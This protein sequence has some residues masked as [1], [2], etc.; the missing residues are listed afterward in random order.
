L[1]QSLR[2][3]GD[4]SGLKRK[5]F[6]YEG[7]RP[8]V[9]ERR[10]L[11]DERERL[12]RY[13]STPTSSVANCGSDCATAGETQFLLHAFAGVPGA[14]EFAEEDDLAGVVGVVGADVGDRGG[15]LLEVGVVGGLDE[16]LEVG[17]DLVELL[18]G[19]GPGGCVELVE[20]LLV[21]AVV[22]GGLGIPHVE[23]H[24]PVPEEEVVGEHADGM[25]GRCGIFVG[26]GWGDPVGLLGGEAADGGVDGDEPLGLVVGGAELLDEDRAEV[27]GFGPGLR[28]GL[29][30]GEGEGGEEEGEE[31]SIEEHARSVLRP[32]GM[33]FAGPVEGYQ[34][35][36]WVGGGMGRNAGR[37]VLGGGGGGWER[38]ACFGAEAHRITPPAEAVGD[39][40]LDAMRRSPNGGRGAA[41][42]GRGG[43]GGGGVDDGA[44]ERDLVGGKA[45]HLGVFVD[46]GLVGR[47]V[48]AVDLVAGDEA[49]D[50]LELGADGGD[51]AAGFLG[52]GLELVRG[53]VAG[54]GDLAL[55]DEFGHG[56]LARGGWVEGLRGRVCAGGGGVKRSVGGP[57]DCVSGQVDGG[58]GNVPR[59][60]LPNDGN[61]ATLVEVSRVVL[62]CRMVLCYEMCFSLW[63]DLRFGAGDA[64]GCGGSEACSEYFSLASQCFLYSALRHQRPAVV[65]RVQGDSE[66]WIGY[67]SDRLEELGCVRFHRL[68][69]KEQLRI[70]WLQ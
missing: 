8:K 11:R 22:G 17:E 20:G 63:I 50:P 6:T 41:G 58:V 42:S 44:D 38:I 3:I 35:G 12:R 18:D 26:L 43:V 23:E 46:G 7:L 59:N 47:D 67:R 15:P 54:S 1:P 48:D 9:F 14:P 68:G 31:K 55:D 37:W 56:G 65:R 60:C 45:A 16:V 64:E 4:R 32:G 62:F 34:E 53:E 5:V 40:D 28:L 13:S 49:L 69:S 2:K 25:V 10:G 51:D 21:G 70:R 33:G 19:G 29:G 36:D 57:G 66:R 24:I 27:G 39:P 30:L 61:A 52:D